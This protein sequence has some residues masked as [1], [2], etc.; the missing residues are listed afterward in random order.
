MM[1]GEMFHS[2]PL[3]WLCS[4]KRW[5]M[6]MGSIVRG[7][8]GEHGDIF[9]TFARSRGQLVRCVQVG[10]AAQQRARWYRVCDASIPYVA[11]S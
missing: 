3:E 11:P 4:P 6:I 8:I 5:D 10:Y 1:R 2:I 7:A 9:F